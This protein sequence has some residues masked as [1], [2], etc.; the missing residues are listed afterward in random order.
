[1]KQ[2]NIRIQDETYHLLKEKS[3]QQQQKEVNNAKQKKEKSLSI[4]TI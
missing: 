3:K 4:Q 2:I 1:M